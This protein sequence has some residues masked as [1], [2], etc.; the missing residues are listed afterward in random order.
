MASEAGRVEKLKPQ[1]PEEDGQV[2]WPQASTDTPDVL[3][4]VT[5]ILGVPVYLIRIL[6]HLQKA[7]M[8]S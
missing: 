1:W 8:K 4:K 3:L 5:V 2:C 6:L 7:V